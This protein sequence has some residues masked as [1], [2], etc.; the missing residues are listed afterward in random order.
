MSSS[1][2]LISFVVDCGSSMGEPVMVDNDS[3]RRYPMKTSKLDLVKS[4][5]NTYMWLRGCD[6]K[7]L[8]FSFHTFG[9]DKETN[10]NHM[11]D[12]GYDGVNEIFPICHPSQDLYQLIRMLEAGP[13][14]QDADL[15]SAVIVCFDRLATAKLKLAFNRIM[16]LITDGEKTIGKCDDD[17]EDL[18]QVVGSM[19]LEDKAMKRQPMILHVIMIGKVNKHSKDNKKAENAILLK[20]LAGEYV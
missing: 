9:Q 13:S 6:S 15:I 7:T 5:V 8:E 14:E 4:F 18:Q 12:Q 16:V 20:Q 3:D 2:S 17:Y 1:K 19:G 10:Q 11:L